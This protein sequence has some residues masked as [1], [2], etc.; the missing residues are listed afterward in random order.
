MA[1]YTSQMNKKANESWFAKIFK[2]FQKKGL[3]DN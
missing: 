3:I 1:D 2:L